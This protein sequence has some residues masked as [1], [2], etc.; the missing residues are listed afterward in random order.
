MGRKNKKV[1]HIKQED[2]LFLDELTAEEKKHIEQHLKECYIC[3]EKCWEVVQI[4]NRLKNMKT[5]EHLENELLTRYVIFKSSADA[6][7]KQPTLTTAEINSV[8]KHLQQCPLCQAEY[9]IL[10]KE[11]T[12]LGTYFDK[13]VIE[14]PFREQN[15]ALG[16]GKGIP[17]EDRRVK[18][19]DSK[20]TI[21]AL[22]IFG[23]LALLSNYYRKR[24]VRNTLVSFLFIIPMV[25]LLKFLFIS[26]PTYPTGH[27]MAYHENIYLED[28]LADR[29]RSYSITVN[30]P[31]NN[32]NFKIASLN[33]DI[34]ILF[35][36]FVQATQFKQSDR[37]RLKIFN[38]KKEDY[39][40]DSAVFEE[41]L[42]LEPGVDKYR[43]KENRPV[44]LSP[45]LY[46]FTI[47]IHNKLL[48]VGKFFVNQPKR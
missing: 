48:Y 39:V 24:P 11:Y 4:Q 19:Q 26:D 23:V 42:D 1:D 41:L 25:F 16:L 18:W 44:Q 15:A 45:G 37:L 32:T 43:F 8:E 2:L 35:T 6:D 36:G 33:Q 10:A 40:N 38:N 30:T 14:T 22:K 17:S 20:K 12:E 21:A 47:D 34:E 46:Y 7:T 31:V 28:L 3:A 27:L 13:I 5:L 9:H 29:D